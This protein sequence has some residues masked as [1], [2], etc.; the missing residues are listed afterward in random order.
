MSWAFQPILAAAAQQQAGGGAAYSLTA[1]AGTFGLNGETARGLAMRRLAAANGAVVV[2]GQA[3]ALRCGRAV[4]GG[5]ASF[6]VTG[7]SASFPGI[8]FLDAAAAAFAFNGGPIG[9]A[10]ARRIAAAG[11]GVT[12]AGQSAEIAILMPNLSAG[13]GAV[14]ILGRNVQLAMLRKLTAANGSIQLSGGS[15]AI[16]GETGA[17]GAL[18]SLNLGLSI[19]F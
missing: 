13:V 16:P 5:V 15:A 6:G 3:V 2:G 11:G 9:A 12:V 10:L 14:A 4:S 17:S 8:L 18:T 19:G 1:S 7:V